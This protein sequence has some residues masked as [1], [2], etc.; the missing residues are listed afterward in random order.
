MHTEHNV[1][2]NMLDIVYHEAMQREAVQ[3]F[4]SVLAGPQSESKLVINRNIHHRATSNYENTQDPIIQLE[5][6]LEKPA[7]VQNSVNSSGTGSRSRDILNRDSSAGLK[8]CL[9]KIKEQ[10]INQSHEKQEVLGVGLEQL[11]KKIREHFEKESTQ[12]NKLNSCCRLIGEQAISLARFSFRLIDSMAVEGETLPQKC[13]RIVIS[14]MCQIL[15]DMGSIFN[16]LHVNQAELTLLREL[17]NQFYNLHVLFLGRESL[18]NS[19]WTVAHAIPYFAQVLYDKYKIGYGIL[20]MQGKESNNA[21]IKESL[22]H[23]NRSCEEGGHNKWRQVF[24]S[25]YVRNFYI[26]EFEPQPD[27]YISHF[28]SRIPDFCGFENFCECGRKYTNYDEEDTCPTDVYRLCNICDDEFM[29][30]VIS[31]MNRGEIHEALLEVLLPHAC[32][33]CSSRFTTMAN[34]NEHKVNC[35][36]STSENEEVSANEPKDFSILSVKE[37]KAELSSR[38]IKCPARPKKNDLITLLEQYESRQ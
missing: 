25:D 36:N 22:A 5:Q 19:V 7:S 2:L 6:S 17:G 20:S 33:N 21:G 27:R 24:V 34:L 10:G 1:W 37:L 31:S 30:Y 8:Q 3:Q 12:H 23:S 18:T 16:K 9:T 15:R 29:T 14:K 32:G 4:L 26:P 11:A 38:G 35:V 13:K 28:V